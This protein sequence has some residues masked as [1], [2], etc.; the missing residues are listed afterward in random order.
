MQTNLN[1]TILGA[2]Y[3]NPYTQNKY[4]LALLVFVA[5]LLISKVITI[6]LKRYVAY[7][8]RKTKTK[9][10]DRIIEVA[11]RP[12]YYILILHGLKIAIIILNLRE[13][14]IPIIMDIITSFILAFATYLVAKVIVILIEEW[15]AAWAKKTKSDLDDQLIPLFVRF[16]NVIVYLAGLMVILSVWG[17]DIT[18]LL[19]GLGIAGLALGFAVKDSLANIFGGVSLLLDN[20]FKVGDKIRFQNGQVGVVLDVGLR[21]TRIKTYDNELLIVPNGQLANEWIMNFVQPD[22]TQ[23]VS[24]DFGVMYGAKH[25][26]VKKTVMAAIKSIKGIK[27]DP[28]P[29]VQFMDM[30]DFALKFT[31]RFWVDDYEKA[32]DR[33]EEAV[34]KIYDALN[35]AKIGIPFP[36]STVYIKQEK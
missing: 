1:E 9:V 7:L 36:T 23:R 16:S 20:N 4:I 25:G 18:G 13:A 21:S 3:S 22:K 24:V 12:A 2:I 30:G 26:D 17:V 19:A 11:E 29:T 35:T 34:C 10:D 31:A 27:K 14:V 28:E 15:G 8:T 5:S 32:P 6:I 33:R